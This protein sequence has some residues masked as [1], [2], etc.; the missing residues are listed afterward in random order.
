ML[1]A[2]QAGWAGGFGKEP[3]LPGSDP[4]DALAN[5]FK[6]EEFIDQACAL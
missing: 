1:H 5:R 4:A 3:A 6:I 2:N